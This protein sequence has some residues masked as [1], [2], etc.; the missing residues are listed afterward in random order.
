MQ[1]NST[2]K[3]IKNITNANIHKIANKLASSEEL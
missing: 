2:V 3:G 1:R